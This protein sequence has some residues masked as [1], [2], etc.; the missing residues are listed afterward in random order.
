MEAWSHL[1]PRRCCVAAVYVSRKAHLRVSH[2]STRMRGVGGGGSGGRYGWGR[3]IGR[4]L[5]ER[6]LDLIK[7]N[8]FYVPKNCKYTIKV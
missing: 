3:V 4:V 5:K 8:R 2:V 6:W 7:I 1:R